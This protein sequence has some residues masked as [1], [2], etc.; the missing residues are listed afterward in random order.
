MKNLLLTLVGVLLVAISIIGLS[1]TLSSKA[2]TIKLSRQPINETSGSA[3]TKLKPGWRLGAPVKH[4]NLTV[5]PVLSDEASGTNEFITLDA[6]IRSG[7]VKVTEMTA[8]HSQ[9]Q[10]ITPP[11]NVQNNQAV[12]QQATYQ[13]D[14]AQV[15][16][17]LVTNNSGKTLV[18]IAGEF[19]LGGKQ[20]RIVGHD[21]IVSSTNAPMPIDVFCVEH[22]R[23]QSR[24]GA[25]RGTSS[26]ASGGVSHGYA[27]SFAPADEVMAAPNVRANAQAKKSQS[28]GR[29]HPL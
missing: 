27:P 13:G 8:N 6:G 19:I 18:L 29:L 25:N 3:P 11:H 5:F 12:Q 20:D 23:W 14:G 28:A 17:V 16:K 26:G 21:C 1:K 10:R 9:R 24:A 7:K 4:E 22:G 15:N 2:E